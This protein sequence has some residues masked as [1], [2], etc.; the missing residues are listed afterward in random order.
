MRKMS[1][2]KLL[3]YGYCI[4]EVIFNRLNLRLS[5]KNWSL[6]YIFLKK[7]ALEYTGST[8]MT[9]IRKRNASFDIGALFQSP[10]RWVKKRAIS[11]LTF[12]LS[13]LSRSCTDCTSSSSVWIKKREFVLMIYSLT[14]SDIKFHTIL[15]LS[16]L[17]LLL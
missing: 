1:I 10:D 6:E 9:Q 13:T 15:I 12:S 16:M 14:I 5:K 4:I 17:Y 3:F 7:C 8:I 2:E 11:K